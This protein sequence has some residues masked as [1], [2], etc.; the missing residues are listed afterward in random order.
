M[1]RALKPGLLGPKDLTAGQDQLA[2]VLNYIK[3]G[4]RCSPLLTPKGSKR[5]I[6]LADP[7]TGKG[8]EP[9]S[10]A[11]S[12]R[13]HRE[14]KSLS[15]ERVLFGLSFTCLICLGILVSLQMWA[16]KSNSDATSSED[17]HRG[18]RT[19]HNSEPLE[20]KMV[21]PPRSAAP[22]NALFVASR[23]GFVVF[24]GLNS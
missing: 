24:T 9:P 8:P 7:F 15:E 17:P 13:R 4:Q 12:P 20:K 11:R 5:T 14:A 21:R 23:S 2:H 6:S 16:A 10:Q 18:G 19:H 1:P 3:L 22:S